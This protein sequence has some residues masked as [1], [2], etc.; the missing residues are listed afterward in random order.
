[1]KRRKNLLIISLCIMLFVM[2]VGYSAFSSKLNINSTSSITSNWDVEIT[3]IEQTNKSGN[4]VEKSKSFTKDT[5]SFSVEMEKP[6]NYVYYKIGITNNIIH[7]LIINK[8][9]LLFI[10]SPSLLKY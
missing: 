9:F 2:A 3:S 5:A 6:G 10:N 8:F 7:K 1:M 4:I